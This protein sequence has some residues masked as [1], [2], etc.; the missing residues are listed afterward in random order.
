MFHC[1]PWVHDSK[2]LKYN[3]EMLQ[4]KTHSCITSA[5]DSSAEP[6]REFSGSSLEGRRRCQNVSNTNCFLKLTAERLKRFWVYTWGSILLLKLVFT[7]SSALRH[8]DWNKI[9]LINFSSLKENKTSLEVGNF[10]NKVSCHEVV[11]LQFSCL[12]V[13]TNDLIPAEVNIWK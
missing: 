1:N 2:L 6:W 8:L 12:C 5:A 4:K 3:K 9:L 11:V 13:I 7:P 10:S